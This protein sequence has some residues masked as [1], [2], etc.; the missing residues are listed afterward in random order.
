MNR[1]LV[2]ACGNP[3]RGDDGIA[4]YLARYLRNEFCEPQT[5]IQCSQQWAPELAESISECDMVLFLDASATLPPGDV[6]LQKI[7]PSRKSS[8]STTH[9][10]S[11]E[12]LLA[13]AAK[14]YS[15][16]PERAFLLTV[17]GESFEH[18][19]H[20]SESV[21]GAIPYAL[22][23]IKATLSGVSLPE[24]TPRSQGAVS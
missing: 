5:E 8:P 22:E 15:N 3:L 9:S 2:L 19:D 10:M 20:L 23:L 14:L 6:Q 7:K 18:A 21:R 16:A 13:L 12:L 4:V 24:M 11:P 17:G 1:A